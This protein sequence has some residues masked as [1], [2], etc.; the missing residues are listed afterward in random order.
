MSDSQADAQNDLLNSLLG[1]FLDESD[2]LLTQ[3]NERLL[4]LDE[5]VHT[6][7]DDAPEPC[8]P[9]LLNEMFRAA[10]SIKGLSAM[11]GLTDINNLTHK[12][13]NVFDAARKNELPVN[14]EVTELI[15]M[16]LDQLSALIQRLKTPHSAPVDCSAVVDSIGRLLQIANSR[17]RRMRSRPCVRTPQRKARHRPAPLRR[18]PPTPAHRATSIRWATCGTKTRSRRNTFRSSSTKARR[19]WTV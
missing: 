12:V 18:K 6:L 4:Q 13:E 15:F 2:Q 17:P 3:L 10:H 19:R 1:D 7:N 16:G 14:G 9:N 11:L 8:D 5:W